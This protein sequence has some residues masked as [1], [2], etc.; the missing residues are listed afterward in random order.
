MNR[1]AGKHAT[2]QGH[3]DTAAED[4]IE[5][6]KGVAKKKETRRGAMAGVTAILAGDGILT[7]AAARG[8]TLFYPFILLDGPARK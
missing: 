5:K 2:L 8:E 1:V 3:H 6:G 4:W 7:G